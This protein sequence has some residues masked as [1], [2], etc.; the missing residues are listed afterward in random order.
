MRDQRRT[1]RRRRGGAH[2]AVPL[3]ADALEHLS[4]PLALLGEV[5]VHERL[6][7]AKDNVLCALLGHEVVLRLDG[8]HRVDEAVHLAE[9]RRRREEEERVLQRLGGR[10]ERRD[11]V[12][13]DVGGD[14][15][16][17]VEQDVRGGREDARDERA[18]AVEDVEDGRHEVVHGREVDAI[19]LGTRRRLDFAAGWSDGLVSVEPSHRQERGRRDTRQV[20]QRVVPRPKHGLALLHKHLRDRLTLVHL[21]HDARP[22][23]HGLLVARGVGAL[24]LGEERRLEEI[25]RG[26]DVAQRA[27]ALG[28]GAGGCD[29]RVAEASEGREEAGALHGR[30][31]RV[32]EDEGGGRVRLERRVVGEEERLVRLEDVDEGFGAGTGREEGRRRGCVGEVEGVAAWS[33]TC[34]HV[35][36]KR[37]SLKREFGRDG[38]SSW[39]PS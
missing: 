29:E 32:G 9:R 7:Y 39:S 6:K 13:D 15:L 22:V 10:E 35:T 20:A 30:E 14:A 1:D 21:P 8:E 25:H 31:G 11:V 18:F 37:R 27:E 28:E 4:D 2:L 3:F 33:R 19:R 16:E 12:R 34:G 23:A 17:E 36:A 24:K 5:V 38:G 26:L